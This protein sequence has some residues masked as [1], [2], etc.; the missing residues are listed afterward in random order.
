MENEGTKA[1]E[2]G[3]VIVLGA[4]LALYK[5]TGQLPDCESADHPGKTFDVPNY[6]GLMTIQSRRLR[7]QR[8]SLSFVPIFISF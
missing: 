2:P 1:S 8:I 3:K 5:S 4:E 7:W 6:I